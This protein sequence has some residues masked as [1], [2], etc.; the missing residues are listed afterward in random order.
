[1]THQF[2]D[3]VALITGGASGIGAATA[4]RIVDGGGSVVIADIQDDLGRELVATWGDAGH[5][6]HLDVTSE[7]EW[8]RA[9][10]DTLQ[11]FGRLDI[12]VN[13][14][15]GGHYEPIEDTSKETWDR[16]IA[17]SQTS[18]FL[19]TKAAS[20]A[21]HASGHGSVVNISSVYGLVGGTGGSPA[22]HAAKGAVR[23]LTKNTAI[24]WWPAGVRVNSVHPGFIDTPLLKDNRDSIAAR[25]PSGRLGTADEVAAVIAFLASDEA[26]FVTGSEY[27]VD[28]GHTAS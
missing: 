9:I 10:D 16:V 21:L 6:V 19:G 13:N 24:A 8:T 12:L 26:S 17:L 23:L 22:Y 1:M 5:Y 14:A 2:R 20:S 4:R 28:G 15:G 25:T 11:H 7:Q 27:V 18:V 3:R